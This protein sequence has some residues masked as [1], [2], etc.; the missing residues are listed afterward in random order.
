MNPNVNPNMNS[1]VNQATPVTIEPEMMNPEEVSQ[2]QV[3]NYDDVNT[4]AQTENK[5]S[6]GKKIA[7]FIAIIGTILLSGG[8]AYSLMPEEVA[9][10]AT[11]ESTEKAIDSNS[12]GPLTCTMKDD[13]GVDSLLRTSTYIFSFDENNLLIN[14]NKEYQFSTIEGNVQSEQKYTEQYNLLKNLSIKLQKNPIP[15]YLMTIGESAND[16]PTKEFSTKVTID[17]NLID[18][19]LITKEIADNTATNLDFVKG[20][21][22]D[23]VL[24]TVEL[25]GSTCK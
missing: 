22:R 15:G 1:N 6:L 24:K 4:A 21:T 2:A 16:T 7:I 23:Q 8:I 10:P 5:N 11:S 25:N 12:N 9:A 13:Q 3:L 14:Y 17:L 20:T 18:T 19:T